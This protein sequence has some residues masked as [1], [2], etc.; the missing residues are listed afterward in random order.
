MLPVFLALLA[1]PASLAAT[2]A[3]AYY[4]PT[5]GGGSWLDV[6]GTDLGEPMNVRTHVP[7]C[8]R[9]TDLASTGGHFGT[10][11]ARCSHQRRYRQLRA[12]DRVVSSN[13]C[14]RVER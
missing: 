6:A 12:L 4:D 5:V 3:P 2:V 13:V 7:T 1:V 9:P 8:A 10:Q 11:L 14:A